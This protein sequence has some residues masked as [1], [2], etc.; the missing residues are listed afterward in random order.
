MEIYLLEN[1]FV[2]QGFY[3]TFW[4]QNTDL[5]ALSQVY[6]QHVGVS[7]MPKNL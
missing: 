1:A 4:P 6:L 3:T 5:M 7:S 2:R